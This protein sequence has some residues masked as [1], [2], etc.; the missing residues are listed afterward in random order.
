MSKILVIGDLMIDHYI[1]GDCSRISPEAPVQVVNVKDE[2]SVLGGAGNVVNNILSLGGSADI[3]SVVGDCTNTLHL[4]QLLAENNISDEFLIVERGR[5]SSKKTRII[6]SKQQVVRYDSES[7]ADI[8]SANE[9]A[10]FELFTKIIANYKVVILSDYG[11]GV[12]TD[13]LTH[14]IITL[15]T[16]HNIKV[17]VDPKGD[18]YAKYS[19][20]YL[21]TP[22]KSEAEKALQLTIS[23]ENV[24]LAAKK[25][26]DD[27]NL[28]HSLITLSEGGIAVFDKRLRIHPTKA[29]E[30]FDVSGAGD[31]VIASLAIKLC[32]NDD[33]D[34][35]I[36]FANLVAGVV[37]AKIG[38]A[39]A[40]L[41]E[42]YAKQH[43]IKTF[44]EIK[45]ISEHLKNQGKKIIFTN[46]CFD[47]LHLG[48]IKYLEEAKNLGDILIVGVN[49]DSSV[50]RLKGE[51]RPINLE[52]DRAYLLNALNAVDFVVIFDEETPYNLI[53][54][55]TPDVLVKG[56]DYKD[57]EVV[58]SDIA[59]TTHLIEFVDGKSTTSIIEK[60]QND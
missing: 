20:A 45:T 59:K 18:D 46:G 50:R 23:A 19:G 52:F 26:K 54:T 36:K 7:V 15:A 10:L 16:K 5:I 57:K 32:E 1:M 28:T 39:T 56:G 11:K 37:V 27:Y 9:K 24:E 3:L 4:Q 44:A 35:A 38:T 60:I 51:S 17:L 2:K 42:V 55:I 6:A 21:L 22:N 12:L 47:I 14:R 53:Q 31:S 13:T 43:N 33:I 49:A 30:V 58:G 41:D 34:K 29:R 48:H 25:L 40:T 8:S